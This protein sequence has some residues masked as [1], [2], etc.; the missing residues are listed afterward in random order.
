MMLYKEH[1]KTVKICW[2]LKGYDTFHLKCY[3]FIILKENDMVSSVFRKPMS[4]E[5]N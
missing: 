1:S 5:I 2:S 3:T 4:F